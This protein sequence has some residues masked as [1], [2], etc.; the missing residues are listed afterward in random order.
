[1]THS[2][3]SPEVASVYT[4]INNVF[5]KKGGEDPGEV[6]VGDLPLEE[7]PAGSQFMPLPHLIFFNSGI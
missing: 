7:P 5:E 6:V 2:F 4:N 1:M 3:A